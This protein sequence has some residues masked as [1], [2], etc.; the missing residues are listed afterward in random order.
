M[1]SNFNE[2]LPQDESY[3]ILDA[4]ENAQVYL[5]FQENVNKKEFRLQ[6]EKSFNESVSV[7]IEDYVQSHPSKKHDFFSIPNGTIHGAGVNN[8]VLEIS[9]APYI[10]TF[11]IYDWV[12][13]DLNGQPRTLNIERA[14]ENLDFSRKGNR[15]VEQNINNIKVIHEDRDCKTECLSTST[16]QFYNVHRIELKTKFEFKTNDCFSVMSLVEGNFIEV[17]QQN[18]FIKRFNYA[19]TFIIPAAAR[20]FILK[21]GRDM[22]CKVLRAFIK[23]ELL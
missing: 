17:E 5:G 15:V 20:S 1:K 16:E 14:F 23:P 2:K 3:Y 13:L 9:S 10:F 8:L 4:K 6:M 19:E 12:R 7:Q 22:P 11:K 18:G 21:N